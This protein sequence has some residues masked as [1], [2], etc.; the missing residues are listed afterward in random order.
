[1]PN[2]LFQ[3]CFCSYTSL[4]FDNI[5]IGCAESAECL[6]LTNGLCISLGAK[7]YDIGIVTESNEIFKVALFCCE[8]GLKKPESLCSGASQM[9]CCKV[10]G[11]FPF[12]GDY[13][14]EPICALCFVS[15]KPDVGIMT[16]APS[17]R[18]IDRM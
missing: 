2:Y 18:S 10:V 5:K 17:C 3:A 7:P 6:C 15:C 9:L 1:M 14:G 11:S 13:V 16:E 8:C 4:D 12:N